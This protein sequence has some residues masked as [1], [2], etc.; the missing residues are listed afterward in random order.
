[1]Y[2]LFQMNDMPRAQELLQNL[3]MGKKQNIRGAKE[4]RDES[5]SEEDRKEYI[6]G[7]LKHLKEFENMMQ[8]V[9]SLVFPELDFT[10]SFQTDCYLFGCPRHHHPKI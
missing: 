8:N 10:P 7:E 5:W 6:K 3:I 4:D 2:A 1:M 9:A